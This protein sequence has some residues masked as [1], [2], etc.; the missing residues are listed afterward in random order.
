MTH[1]EIQQN[2]DTFKQLPYQ[3]LVGVKSPS[4]SPATWFAGLFVF[5]Q[6]EETKFA[7]NISIAHVS[8]AA[9]TGL[10][11]AVVIVGILILTWFVCVND[12]RRTK[13]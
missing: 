11:L 1:Q 5:H 6:L 12:P 7:M 8:L 13:H 10:L 9:G 4:H 2:T 3:R